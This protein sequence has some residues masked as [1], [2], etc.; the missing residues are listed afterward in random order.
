MTTRTHTLLQVR[1]SFARRMLTR[2]FIFI[3]L[4]LLWFALTD[5]ACLTSMARY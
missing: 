1:N 2:T 3:L 5:P 4:P